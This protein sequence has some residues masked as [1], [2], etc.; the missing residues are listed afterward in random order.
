MGDPN[1]VHRRQARQCPKCES[2]VVRRSVLRWYESPW[3]MFRNRPSRCVDCDAR[4]WCSPSQ[5]EPKGEGRR[6]VPQR[7]LG[8][9]WAGGGSDAELADC[10]SVTVGIGGPLY[11]GRPVHLQ[12]PA[13]QLEH[14]RVLVVVAAA[15]RDGEQPRSGPARRAPDLSTIPTRRRS[16]EPGW[17]AGGDPRKGRGH[18]V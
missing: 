5:P 7:A 3:R 18:S 16:G 4:F 15:H 14:L 11:F 10:S 12:E 8:R 13:H 9:Y 1:A 6:D 17:G 2:K